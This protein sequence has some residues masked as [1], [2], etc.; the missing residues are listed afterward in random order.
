MTNSCS[1]GN[2]CSCIRSGRT[3]KPEFPTIPENSSMHMPSREVRT[4]VSKYSINR[5]LQGQ[6]L[7]WIEY[8]IESWASTRTLL[9]LRQYW[10]ICNVCRRKPEPLEETYAVR[11]SPSITDMRNGFDRESNPRPQRWRA[12]MLISNIDLSTAPLL[13]AQGQD[14]N[15]KFPP[16]AHA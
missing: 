15:G 8:W 14:V 3:R 9:A 16:S 5:T 6:D 12:L 11:E 13:T 2:S 1:Y 4:R 7:N 10:A